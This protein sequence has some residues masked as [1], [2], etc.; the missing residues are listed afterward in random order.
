MPHQDDTNL[1]PA[2]N[3][4][5]K[6]QEPAQ[7]FKA[8][9][10]WT[11]DQVRHS[12]PQLEEA[13]KRRNIAWLA[14]T[15]FAS[16]L[17]GEHGL[18]VL[19]AVLE[20]I[21]RISEVNAQRFLVR[22]LVFFKYPY[23]ATAIVEL[24]DINHDRFLRKEICHNLPLSKA[25]NIDA[26]ARRVLTD[27]AYG[28]KHADCRTELAFLSADLDN[29]DGIADILVSIFEEMPLFIPFPLGKLA[30]QRHLEFMRD[31]LAHVED[32][33]AEIRKDLRENLEMA[34]RKAEKRVA[35]QAVRA[36]KLAQ[37]EAERQRLREEK[38]R[39][40]EER[41]KARRDIF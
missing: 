19:A 32:Y 27:P 26:W 12:A 40:K 22:H 20:V 28:N 38:Q 36:E 1:V 8:G 30:E 25:R 31:R 23:D 17:E 2:I 7:Y 33:P 16:L 29:T 35:R 5:R 4:N 24:F 14:N 18:E 41:A 10:I 3:E 37:K 6:D 13:L 9:Q 15:S 34:I 21:G 39:M 11:Q